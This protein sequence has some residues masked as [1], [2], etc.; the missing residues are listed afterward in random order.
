MGY[1][2]VD[3]SDLDPAPDH[4]SDRRSVSEAV[5]LSTLAAAVYEIAP[6]EQLPQTY[7]SHEVREELFYVDAGT[8]TVKTPEKS[9]VVES[10]QVFVAEPDSPH[11][12]HVPEEADGPARVLG[13]GAPQYDPARPFDPDS[14]ESADDLPKEA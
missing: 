14:D 1:H 11:L 12:A 9:V 13:V 3:P 4:P 10:G 8:L 5:G 2:V 6:G 7:H